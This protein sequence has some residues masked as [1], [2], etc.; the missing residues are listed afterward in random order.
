MHIIVCIK[1]VIDPEIPPHVFQIDPVE[2][3]QIRG[4]QALVIGTFDE[5]AIEMGLQLK[6]KTDGKVTILT[7]D[8]EE[9]KESLHQALAM[10]ANEAILLSDPSFQEAD[11]YGKARILAAAIK[12]LGDAD[13][14]LCGRQAGD[15]ELGLVGMFLGEALALPS[16]NLVAQIEPVNAL[17]QAQDPGKARL[18]RP[19]E[20]GY[21]V[22]EAPL[23][24]LGTAVNDESN[25][26]RYA[27]VRG[28]RKAMRKKI[29]VW[30][31]ADLGIDPAE[32]GPEAVRIE[33]EE[34]YIPERDVRCEFIEG[35]SGEEKAQL[36]VQ[37]L[38][39]LQVI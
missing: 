14:V 9:G 37:R 35:E 16:V 6:E 4:T 28:I 31:A 18:K 27:S 5:V 24:F 8:Q 13:V 32:I 34:L 33:M 10:G 12:K 23:P 21:E 22:L 36:L 19:I 20:G 15:V 39:E 1:Q 38:K 7:I 3:K 25:V 29:P 2:K 11:A 26:P 30:S 17:R